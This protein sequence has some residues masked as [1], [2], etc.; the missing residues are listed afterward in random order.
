M[1]GNRGTG[2]ILQNRDRLLLRELGV[3]RVIDRELVKCVGGFKSTT[4]ANARLLA[5]TRAGLLRRFFIGSDA[6]AKKALYALTP[7]GARL[8]GGVQPGLRRK[9][10]AVLVADYFV[11]HQLFVNQIYCLVKYWEIPLPDARF[12]RWVHFREPIASGTSLIPD[13]YFELAQR[14]KVTPA[15]LEVDLGTE[16]RSVW[17]KKVQEYLNYAVGGNAAEQFGSAQFRV[18]VV[19]N[20]EP[21]LRSLQS[22]TAALT[23]KIF[24]FTTFDSI[25]RDGFWAPVWL[26]PSDDARRALIEAQ[27]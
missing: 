2:I 17:R 22:T 13:G 24:W 26:R 18:L 11:T 21:R 10:D 8:G 19:T 3:M 9:G 5:L 7:E 1:N 20:S 14:E 15:F 4:R 27:P 23:E 6:G 16:S 25:E 12:L